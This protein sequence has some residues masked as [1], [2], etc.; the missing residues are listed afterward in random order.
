MHR[1]LIALC[2]VVACEQSRG[3][4]PPIA[5]SVDDSLAA[6]LDTA[7]VEVTG[8]FVR[9]DATPS[10]QSDTAPGRTTRLLADR[11]FGDTAFFA[12]ISSLKVGRNVI[13]ISDR[14]MS[15]HLA[16]LDRA[17]GRVLRNF[18]REGEGPGEFRDP[19]VLELFDENRA[20]IY[21][22]QLRRLTYAD[23]TTPTLLPEQQSLNL[24]VSLLD[25]VLTDSTIVTNGLFPDY[26]L[27]IINRA[28]HSVRKVAGA[29][30]HP[31][32]RVGLPV[33]A[34]L[35]NRT[36]M[37]A[38]PSKSRLA[39]AYQFAPQ[40]DFFTVAGEHYAKASA[41]R[42]LDVRWRTEGNRFFWLDGNESG[43]VAITANESYVYGL[44]CEC[45]LGDNEPPPPYLH[46]YDWEGNFVGEWQFDVTVRIITVE[47][48]DPSRLVAVVEDPYPQIAEFRVPAI[49]GR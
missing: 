22:F 1:F 13:W 44:F 5:S 21:D 38:D 7:H 36:Y 6:A 39:V 30:P 31:L 10:R 46:V 47:P 40:I 25:P 32:E 14:M 42:D 18:G 15:P 43:Y 20:L 28:D 26:T 12:R 17:D 49:D 9:R 3:N 23:L 34:R 4:P 24:G 29:L 45:K 35:M 2:C 37:V 8:G 16:V 33:A 11:V 19:V 41:P 48:S 27:A